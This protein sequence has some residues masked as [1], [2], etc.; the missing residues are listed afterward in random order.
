MIRLT[1]D[2]LEY[3]IS[4]SNLMGPIFSHIVQEVC[5]S[6]ASLAEL[7]SSVFGTTMFLFRILNLLFFFYIRRLKAE[8]SCL[9]TC[10]VG[11]HSTMGHSDDCISFSKTRVAATQRRNL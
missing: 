4:W 3:L 8:S 10:S 6:S 9:T 5:C 11:N 7:A 1:S 2:F